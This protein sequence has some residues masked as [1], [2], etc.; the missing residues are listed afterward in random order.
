MGIGEMD[1]LTFK[2][3]ECVKKCLEDEEC[4]FYA[5]LMF[6]KEISKDLSN[7]KVSRE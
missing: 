6:A 3:L 2:L 1:N 5:M 7:Y 4:K